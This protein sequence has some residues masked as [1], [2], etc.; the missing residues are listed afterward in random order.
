MRCCMDVATIK[1]I[2]ARALFQA[3]S[4]IVVDDVYDRRK[5]KEKDEN[6]FQKVDP[7]QFRSIRNQQ[8]CHEIQTCER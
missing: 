3:L 1:L 2:C 4:C 7:A 5:G 6:P 8:E